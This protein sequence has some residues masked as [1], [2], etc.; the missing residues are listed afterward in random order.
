M[1]RDIWTK[2][3]D[4]VDRA[5]RKLKPPGRR[6]RYSHRLV[7]GMYLWSV[8]H[9]RCLTWACDPT[10]YGDLFRPRALPSVSRF[11]R[12]VKDAV[13]V[14]RR[15]IPRCARPRPRTRPVPQKPSSRGRFVQDEA[16][17]TRYNPHSG[18]RFSSTDFTP[19]ATGAP[20]ERPAT[21]RTRHK[22]LFV[23]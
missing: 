16:T 12:R 9:D 21:C 6:P 23:I 17:T 2:V 18:G 15:S 13:P 20:G 8:W 19:R 10:H 14:P 22:V 7:A 5:I 4:A 11:T 3:M 1:D